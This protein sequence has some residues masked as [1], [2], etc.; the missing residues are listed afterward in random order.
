MDFVDS[1]RENLE[2]LL[3]SK[4]SLVAVLKKK[5][6]SLKEKLSFLWNF[7][8]TLTK[9]LYISHDKMKSFS[10]YVQMITAY[11]ACLSYL[12]WVDEMD[13]IIS[14]EMDFKLSD[15]LHKIKPCSSH[16]I[17]MYFRLL[18]DSM[19]A[20]K[21]ESFFTE[22]VTEFVKFLVENSLDSIK[23]QIDSLHKEL[24]YLIIAL[25]MDLPDN[26]RGDLFRIS[27]DIKA[28]ARKAGSFHVDHV[29]ALAEHQLTVLLK[30]M[31]LLKAR[32]IL[33]RLDNSSKVG[34]MVPLKD[35]LKPLVQVLKF[36]Q[37]FSFDLPDKKQGEE[38]LLVSD[39]VIVSKEVMSLIYSIQENEL[40]KEIVIKMKLSLFLLLPKIYLINTE[41]DLLKLLS[42]K[43]NLVSP[44]LDQIECLHEELR[45]LRTYLMNT[46]DTEDKKLLLTHFEAVVSWSL[47][48]ISS[49]HYSELAT[50]S[51]MSLPRLLGHSKLI[52]A[53]IILVELQAR[54][55]GL[56]APM[57]DQVKRLYQELGFLITF[58]FDPSLMYEEEKE[59]ILS[60]SE[61]VASEAASL[62]FLFN[63]SMM[64]EDMAIELSELIDK[65]VLLKPEI[66]EIYLQIPELLHSNFPMTNGLILV[67]SLLG[68]MRELLKCEPSSI[69]SVKPRMEML[70]SEF[71]FLKDFLLNTVEKHNDDEELKD[72]WTYISH[73]VYEAGYMIDSFVVKEDP[74]WHFM[75]WV[76]FAME[77][78]N[79]ARERVMDIHKK[80]KFDP[81]FHCVTKT[82]FHVPPQATS[83][84]MDEIFVGLEDQKNI[85]IDRLTRGTKGLD[86]IS[87]VGMPGQ[88]KTTLAKE[89]YDCLSVTHIFHIR[90]WCRLSR[91]YDPQEVLLNILGDIAGFTGNFHEMAYDDLQQRLYQFLK[92]RRYLVVIDDFW[93][94]KLWDKLKMSCPNDDNGSRILVTCRTSD[95]VCDAKPDSS[96]HSLRL[97]SDLES[98]NFLEKKVF[99]PDACPPTLQEVGMRISSYCRG[100]PI[101]VSVIGG[102]LAS[103]EM[104][105]DWWKK[106]EKNVT[107]GNFIADP[108]MHVLEFCYEQL[109]P[110]LKPCFLYFAAFPGG[111]EIPVWKLF[112]LWVA[113]GFVEK[114]ESQ[115]LEDV[116]EGYLL[117]LIN[118]NLVILSKRRS[119][120]GVKACLIHDLLW[121][122]CIAKV[123]EEKIML[124]VQQVDEFSTTR[125]RPSICSTP[126]QF[127]ELRSFGPRVRCLF[128]A[129]NNVSSRR[130][131]NI[132]FISENFQLLRVLD[133]E[134]ICIGYSFPTGLEILVLLRYL[135]VRGFVDFV[136]SS[137]A[138]LS[139]LET[140]ILIRLKRD[141]DVAL[142]DTFWS[143]RRLRHVHIK[144]SATFSLQNRELEKSSQLDN[145]ETLSSPVL[146]CGEHSENILRRLPKLRKLK[147]IFRS[148]RGCLR[149]YN[150]AIAFELL[151]HL[152]SLNVT[153]LGRTRYPCKFEFPSHLRKLTLS[154]FCLPWREMST[155]GRLHN[156]EVLKLLDSAFEG[157][158]WETREGEFFK[159]KYLKLEDL[160]IVLWHAEYDSFPCLQQLVLQRCKELKKVPSSFG[161]IVTLQSIEMIHCNHSA[162]RSAMEIQ[163]EQR[164]MGND[165]L[166]VLINP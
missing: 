19:E 144:N 60:T 7:L 13:E 11:T 51:S 6:G 18:K 16:D 75:L 12:C 122:L 89:V 105:L 159:L 86:I 79:F 35:E 107:Y 130:P 29:A 70:Y 114:T 31:Y 15:L 103:T 38:A 34:L 59:L 161:E 83:R 153:Y 150:E 44:I 101:A 111:K 140:F 124:K 1:V 133:L 25:L 108:Y 66:K 23:D 113:E 116:A 32:V 152:E 22:N 158:D 155:I 146:C 123:K 125:H 137:I 63:D 129:S 47:S 71:E 104:K 147:C 102:L 93:D 41:I 135:A 33:R 52:K 61:A 156:L 160:D 82:S 39:A 121:D 131:Y 26:C 9:D 151:T 94:N 157:Q 128:F 162:E 134:G 14:L 2:D 119:I 21:S 96:V 132:S 49:F 20:T 80:D 37:T 40:T 109:P 4:E 76:S 48:L 145:M 56:M 65:I 30:E 100:L 99:H 85:I 143:M 95:V 55:I 50:E 62:I 36:L 120:G 78:I 88:G 136:P 118:R 142:P 58:I 46:M 68:D 90:A 74:V 64:K 72:L 148:L 24:E 87:I 139:K 28:A 165:E 73:V 91:V 163:E 43:A 117:D 27:N 81:R 166:K 149:E 97:F 138:K 115:I 42:L 67:S 17:E 141:F 5:F 154:K 110:H 126:Y 69:S 164:N 77:D 8:Y 127:V 53:E 98:W 10:N 45:F 84:V 92:G 3:V 57:K 54:Q 112:R 106:V